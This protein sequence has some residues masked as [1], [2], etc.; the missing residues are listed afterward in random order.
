MNKR[1]IIALGTAIAILVTVLFLRSGSGIDAVWSVSDS[2]R[3]LA[4][5]VVVSALLDSINP[6]AFA[7]LLVTI[8]ILLGLGTVRGK[9]L[10]IGGA[11]I[12]GI[13]VAYLAIGLGILGTLHLFSVPH[14]MGKLGAVLLIVWGLVN[15]L[16]EYIPSFPIKLRVPHAAHR[17]MAELMG[18]ASLPAAFAL[19][20]LVG[21]CEFPCTGGPYLVVLGLLHDSATYL[22]GFGYLLLYN[23]IF[24]L[25]LFV[26]LTIVSNQ[27]VLERFEAWK[28]S[29][30]R[31]MRLW[32]GIAMLV[33][34][35]L[36]LLL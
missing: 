25:P 13:F 31:S 11:Y 21:L 32:T 15:V 3:L 4:P 36:I 29:N 1:L 22:K 20:A 26:V 10:A 14:F 33:F 28:R 16:N 19:G 2:G 27:S 24:V 7:I 5:L 18:R 30:V 35:V 34:G 9:L 23:A 12:G 6:C 8:A 17:K